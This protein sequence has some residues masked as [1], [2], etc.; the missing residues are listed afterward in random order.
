MTHA[1]MTNPSTTPTDAVS[2]QRVPI[3]ACIIAK[4]EADRI[5]RCI[6]SV[7]WCDEILVVDSGSTDGTQALCRELGARV[8]ETDWPGWVKQKQRAVEAA[9]HDWIFSLDA[10]ECVDDALRTSLLGLR[11]EELRLEDPKPRAFA[12]TRKVHF[13]G[14]WIKHGGWYPEWRIRLFHRK[15]ATWGGVDPHDRIEATCPVE[16]VRPGNLEHYT[17]RSMEDYL[18]KTNTFSTVAAAQKLERGKRARWWDISLRPAFRFFRMYVLRFGFLDGGR[19][20]V[21]AMLDSY[22]VFLK[23]AKLWNLHQSSR[24][25]HV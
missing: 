21:L 16:R 10:D 25:D 8:I 2:K 3:S 19:G 17:W 20:L 4:N 12:V 7:S 23:Y 18:D 15:H 14:G 1:A 11:A 24:R 13:L 22:G 5:R 6:K 9:A